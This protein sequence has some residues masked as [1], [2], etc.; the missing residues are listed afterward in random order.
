LAYTLAQSVTQIR[1]LINEETPGFWDDTEIENW[2]K[3]ATI[4]ISTKLLSV[5]DEQTIILINGQ[6]IYT[7]VEESWIADLIKAKG[8]YYDAGS[9]NVK[10]MQRIDIQKV[11]HLPVSTGIPKYFFENNR[12]F[13]IWPVPTAAEAGNTITVIYGMESD[14]ITDLKD[15][16]QPFAFLYAAAR[17]K[18]K[19]RMFQESALYMSQYISS[20]NFERQDKF[21]MGTDPYATFDLK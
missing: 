16:H 18:A 15:E 2:I 6:W 17:A 14:D 12:N 19:D 20:L 9:G 7:S 21:D 10:G 5:E 11:G 1:S 3:E 8:C 13:Y 4:D